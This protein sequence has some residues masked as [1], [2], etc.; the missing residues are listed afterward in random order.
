MGLL[1][2]Q[3]TRRVPLVDRLRAAGRRRGEPATLAEHRRA[4]AIDRRRGR[5]RQPSPASPPTRRARGSSPGHAGRRVTRE[6][7][8]VAFATD[9]SA[10]NRWWTVA[11]CRDYYVAQTPGGSRVIFHTI[12]PLHDGDEGATG[13]LIADP[14]RSTPACHRRRY[15][16][17][18]PV[19]SIGIRRSP[20]LVL[21]ALDT[22]G[23][24]GDGRLITLGSCGTASTRDARRRPAGRREVLPERGDG[25]IAGHAFVRSLAD[26]GAVG[27]PRQIVGRTLHVHAGFLAIYDKCGGRPRA[28][29]R[30]SARM[31]RALLG[32][33]H[34]VGAADFAAPCSTPRPSTAPRDC[35]LAS[36]SAAR[37]A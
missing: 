19:P 7:A 9:Q 6:R 5:D 37:T 25:Q 22:V 11:T 4:R 28:R 12:S 15:D 24:R 27:A 33:L 31:A 3:A 36:D 35:L 32:R 10:S 1:L 8:V 34:A 29:P 30:R 16:R 13:P 21:D 23:V 17:A 26:A 14:R 2:G 18:M 20:D